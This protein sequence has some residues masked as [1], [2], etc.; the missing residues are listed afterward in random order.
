MELLD[1]SSEPQEWD[2]LASELRRFAQ[3]YVPFR[4]AGCAA[5]RQIL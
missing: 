1:G 5:T 4:R 2:E 3:H